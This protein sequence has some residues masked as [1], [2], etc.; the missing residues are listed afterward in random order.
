MKTM[1][2]IQRCAELITEFVNVDELEATTFMK[3][4]KRIK[5]F[6]SFRLIIMMECIPFSLLL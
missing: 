5:L 2:D 4:T 1:I 6:R 3:L